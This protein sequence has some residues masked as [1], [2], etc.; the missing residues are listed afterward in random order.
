MANATVTGG[1]TSQAENQAKV[2]ELGMLAHPKNHGKKLEA[3]QPSHTPQ[4]Q[5]ETRHHGR[6]RR[7]LNQNLA[8]K[9]LRNGWTGVPER[10]KCFA[11]WTTDG[12]VEECMK[13]PQVDIFN[14]QASCGN[15]T[16]LLR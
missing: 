11:L 13:A 8:M 6:A 9:F 4:R 14:C 10:E 16:T 12:I 7:K 5:D 3:T 2:P 15:I 1:W